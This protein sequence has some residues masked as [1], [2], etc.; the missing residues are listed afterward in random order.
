MGLTHYWERP[1]DLPPND[2]VQAS[3]D[4]KTVFGLLGIPLGDAEGRREAVIDSEQVVF[5]GAHG[6]GCEP[7]IFRRHEEPG[8]GRGNVFGY[9]KTEGLDYD[10]CV[11]CALVILKHYLGE[12]MIVTSDSRDDEWSIPHETCERM[13]GHPLSFSLNSRA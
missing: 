9:C 2:F 5:N 7:F 13:I 4:I 3:E 8:L 1:A 11:R 10:I 6:T 12:R